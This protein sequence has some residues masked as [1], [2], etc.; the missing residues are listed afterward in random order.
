[1]FE[2][3]GKSNPSTSNVELMPKIKITLRQRRRSLISKA[4]GE[5]FTVKN[6]KRELNKDYVSFAI[7]LII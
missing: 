2:N 6:L 4:L 7:G 3:V 5:R 1:M